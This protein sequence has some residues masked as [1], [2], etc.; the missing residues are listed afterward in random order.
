MVRVRNTVVG[1]FTY[2]TDRVS[3]TNCAKIYNLRT[4]SLPIQ[5]PLPIHFSP[6]G[7][8]LD[9]DDVWNAFWM[10]ALLSDKRESGEILQLPHK[11][12]TKDAVKENLRACTERDSGP[13]RENWNHA[14]DLCCAITK[15]EQGNLSMCLHP[16]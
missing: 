9:V 1:C 6:K 10:N 5:L 11:T 14:C 16:V 12:T 4:A 15:D 8:R 13:Y 7:Y 3:G 2:V